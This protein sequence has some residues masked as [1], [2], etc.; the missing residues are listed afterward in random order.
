MH[1]NEPTISEV[2]SAINQLS[3]SIEQRFDGVDDRLEAIE[4]ALWHGEKLGML[5]VQLRRLAERTGNADLA[6]PLMPPLGER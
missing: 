2:L 6:V 5:E 4:R 3:S 1:D